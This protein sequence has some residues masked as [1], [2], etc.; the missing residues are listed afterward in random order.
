M[1]LEN[2]LSVLSDKERSQ[3]TEKLLVVL[4]HQ[5]YDWH[6]D[7][8]FVLSSGSFAESD[9]TLISAEGRAQRFFAAYDKK[10]YVPL[11]DI[12]DAWRWLGAIDGELTAKSSWHNLDELIA[13]VVANHDELADIVH[14]APQ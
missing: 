4:D 8:D 3:L 14:A 10:Y 2:D 7:A 11:S 1:V 6:Q 9:G 5:S 13:E 12:K